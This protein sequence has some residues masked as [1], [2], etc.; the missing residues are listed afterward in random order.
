MR[1][2]AAVLQLGFDTMRYSPVDDPAWT[3]RFMATAT[4]N[5][6]SPGMFLKMIVAGDCADSEYQDSAV[7]QFYK[8]ME[9]ILMI[10]D[11]QRRIALT[12][13]AF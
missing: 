4:L 6:D 2:A 11:R 10:N 5:F 7:G 12:N 3:V 9:K 1:P 13:D 8:E